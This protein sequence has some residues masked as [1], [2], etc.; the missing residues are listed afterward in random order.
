[1]GAR[2]EAAGGH[3]AM[4]IGRASRR[5]SGNLLAQRRFR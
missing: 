1:M 2:R 5:R 4:D 3:P